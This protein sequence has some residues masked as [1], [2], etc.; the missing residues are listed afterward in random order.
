MPVLSIDLGGTKIA[1]AVVDRDG[2][3]LSL[4]KQPVRKESFLATVTQ[5]AEEAGAALAQSKLTWP[6]ISR[7]GLI[8]PGIVRA[9]D[10][11]A[12]AP[13]LWGNSDV[14]LLRELHARLPVPV[15]MDSDRAGYVLGEQWRGIARGV[16]DVVFVAIGTGIGAGILSGGRLI[17]GIGGVAGAVG[18]MALD[19]RFHDAY[20]TLGCWEA[21]SA[22]PGIAHRAGKESASDVAAAARLG[23]GVC[24][25]ALERAASYIAMGIANLISILNPSIVVLGGGV[26]QA[27]DLLLDPVRTN[28]ERWANPIAASQ[29]R[30]ELSRLGDQAGLL[31]A[32]KLAIEASL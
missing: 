8:V 26:M 12:C 2:E 15:T 14:P 23:D 25:L 28:V 20:T 24:L 18:W 4:R 7:I 6:Q 29:T 30:I 13:N 10:G 16:D 17:R 22:G 3:F 19:P 1:A 31:G 32:A 21:E 11:T 9:G 27:A 5:I